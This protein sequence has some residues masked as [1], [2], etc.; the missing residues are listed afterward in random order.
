MSVCH[1]ERGLEG[2]AENTL[3]GGGLRFFKKNIGYRAIVVSPALCVRMGL[4]PL[5]RRLVQNGASP[6]GVLDAPQV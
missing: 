4:E 2:A 1:E 3:A 6:A 5:D